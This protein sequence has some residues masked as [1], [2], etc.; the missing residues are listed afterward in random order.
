MNLNGRPIQTR[1]SEKKEQAF[2]SLIYSMPKSALAQLIQ[3]C[4]GY[5]IA[6]TVLSDYG[7]WVV[8]RCKNESQ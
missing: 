4:T 8:A 6:Y 5:K 2:F 7:Q 3:L 1:I